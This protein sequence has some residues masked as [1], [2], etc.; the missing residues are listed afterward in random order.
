[1]KLRL[2]PLLC[3]PFAAFAQ[4]A[5]ERVVYTCDNGSRIEI[6]RITGSDDRPLAVL[7]FADETLT[8]PQ[9]PAAAGVLYRDDAIRLHIRDEQ[10]LFEDGRGN[11]RRCS[12]GDSAPAT[13]VAS[14][15]PAAP[16][17]FI[18]ITGSVSY[19]QRSALPP[20]AVLVVRVQNLA[21]GTARSLAE[22]RIALAG[23]PLPIAFATSIDRDLLG[24]K[25]HVGVS[26]Y[27]EHG[28]HRL[29][30][31]GQHYPTLSNGEASHQDILLQAVN[32]V[33]AR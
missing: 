29:F 24:K 25:P 26:A 28:G 32:R 6:S 21:G 14:R 2:L 4:N 5:A 20:G 30:A 7:H 12:Q 23:Q 11:T 27:I 22:Q 13:A 15:S 33:P 19:R 16:S 17:S 10:A 3:L 31:S 9:V 18:D 1:M 8:L